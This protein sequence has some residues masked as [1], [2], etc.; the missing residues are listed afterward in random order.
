MSYF[1]EK[2][3]GITIIHL[4]AAYREDNEIF[5]HS[6]MDY[7]IHNFLYYDPELEHAGALCLDM[8]DL[9]TAP[10]A[11]VSYLEDTLKGLNMVL[12]E[13]FVDK[14]DSMIKANFFPQEVLFNRSE[15][16]LWD[17]FNRIKQVTFMQSLPR[18]ADYIHAT[19]ASIQKDKDIIEEPDRYKWAEITLS[20]ERRSSRGKVLVNV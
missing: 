6:P 14:I 3:V 11:N 2:A 19:E 9:Q 8:N 1:I 17:E 10:C 5:R 15:Q 18:L 16:E 12:A 7:H 4:R 13:I 20:E